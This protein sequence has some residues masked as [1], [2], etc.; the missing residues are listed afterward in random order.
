MGTGSPDGVAAA[1]SDPGGAGD[2]V[3]TVLERMLAAGI[4]EA[5]ARDRLARGCVRVEGQIVTDASTPAPWPTR[6]VFAAST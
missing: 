2:V 5:R 3:V 1:G 4:D 6:W